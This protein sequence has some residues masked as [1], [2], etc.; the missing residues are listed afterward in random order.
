MS[1]HGQDFKETH[2]DHKTNQMFIARHHT[3]TNTEQTR[4][5]NVETVHVFE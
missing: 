1:D 2:N 5:Q 4:R 3:T